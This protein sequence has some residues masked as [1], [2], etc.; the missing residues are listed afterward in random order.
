MCT[1]CRSYICKIIELIWRQ[2]TMQTEATSNCFVKEWS[3]MFVWISSVQT[4][5]V[6]FRT[7]CILCFSTICR[8]RSS[9]GIAQYRLSLTWSLKQ[10][11]HINNHP[12][13]TD[14]SITHI[15]NNSHERVDG[16]DAV[17]RLHLIFS[18]FQQNLERKL[19]S[20]FNATFGCDAWKS[21]PK[22]THLWKH[23]H[24]KCN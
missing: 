20:R 22:T 9:L 19:L 13:E 17:A 5:E 8:N 2:K 12:S 6:C 14:H 15:I 4:V 1:K 7:C 11:P 3:V 10:K 18:H 16:A 23:S 21:K 24:Q